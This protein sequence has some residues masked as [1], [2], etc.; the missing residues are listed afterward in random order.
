MLDALDAQPCHGALLFGGMSWK[1]D[2]HA[3][4]TPGGETRSSLSASQA[5]GVALGTRSNAAFGTASRERL[6][7]LPVR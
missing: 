5:P 3:E 7:A 6:T 1:R 4:D 2:D